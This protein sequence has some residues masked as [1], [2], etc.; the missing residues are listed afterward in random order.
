M[1]R[2]QRI[3]SGVLAF[4]LVLGLAACG[5]PAEEETEETPDEDAEQVEEG[6]ETAEAGDW[7]LDDDSLYLITDEGTIDDKSFNQGA[8][9]GLNA[10]ADEKGVKANYLRPQGQDDQL[11]EQAIGQAIDAGAQVVVTPGYFFEIPMANMQEA[12]P[13]TY[14]IGVDFVPKKDT[15]EVDDNGDPITEE[16]I[17]PKTVG[18]L[19]KEQESGFLAG[20]AVVKDGYT[21]LGF[22]GGYPVPAVVN[23]GYGFLAGAQRAA[24]EED[25]ELDVNYTYTNSF[26]AKPEI[27]T[28]AASW[29][30]GGT[31]IIFS[32]G[33][34]IASS[35]LKAAQEYDGKMIGVDVDQA[36]M[37]PEVITSAM[38]NL[39]AGVS[40][41]LESIDD[42]TFEGG[43]KVILGVEEDGVQLPDDFSRFEKFTED[44]YNEIYK[45][46][47][48]N[49]DG[50][51]DEIPSFDEKRD[52]ESGGNPSEFS[53]QFENINLEWIK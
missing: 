50:M 23:Y 2:L 5:E 11:Y 35:I 46:L 21:K 39:K 8:W 38:K 37:G 29:Y 24:E 42:G 27:Q 1:K 52:L 15:G 30:K 19:F 45:E 17:G 33:G 12:H 10:F 18:I 51:R 7:E 53:D 28:M 34:G 41:V 13:E 22:A 26:Q 47:K 32:C 31:E 48:E 14:F 49:K 43:K 9:E 40:E 25:V 4:S 6:G 16:S 44:D 36:D 20:Y 3:L